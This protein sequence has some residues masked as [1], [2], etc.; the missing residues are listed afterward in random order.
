[1]GNRIQNNTRGDS[2]VGSLLWRFFERVGGQVI[3]FLVG[4]VLARLISP[5]EYASIAQ[6]TVF[7]TLA[8]TLVTNGFYAALVQ[9]R[10]AGE[11]DFS[12]VLWFAAL[13]SLLFYLAAFLAAPA[14]AA[15]YQMPVLCPV[16]RVLMLQVP[17]GVVYM[18]QTAYVARN[19][20]F[21][22][23]F[24]ST[25][26]GI[27]VSGLVGIA[28][29]RCGLG[30]WALVGVNLSGTLT[31]TLVLW[32]TVDWRPRLLFRW[33][34][35]KSLLGFGWKCL[36][37]SLAYNF[38]T[39]LPTLIV[40]KAF[41]E[42]S[43][44]Y[45]NKGTT[46]PYSLQSC[47]LGTLDSVLLSAAAREQE[48]REEVKRLTRRAIR[49][50]LYLLCPMMTGLALVARPLIELLL[51]EKWL[52]SVPYFRIACLAYGLNIVYA[53]F[54]HVIQAVGRSDVYLR[55][56]LSRLAEMALLCLGAVK[57][58]L[59]AV[60]LCVYPLFMIFNDLVAALLCRKYL[61]YRLGELWRDV[62][63]ALGLTAAMALPV[64]A[65]GRLS[66]GCWGLL[67]LQCAAGAGIYVLL[68]WLF[69]VES[70][71]YLLGELRRRLSLLT[72]GQ[73]EK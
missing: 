12:S 7:V 61:D 68:S 60:A 23:F 24:F 17:L 15:F 27:L 44:S 36:A 62:A 30:V 54:D 22:R 41:D 2:V 21:R 34:R 37:A 58:G 46:I 59:T 64:L 1:M 40:G 3:N 45:Y 72:G 14:V 31:N 43:L 42:T 69:R 10:E 73:R 47:V 35:V 32:F 70:F 39:Q 8:T 16:L 52:P 51:T 5:G 53:V 9:K 67:A 19:M 55:L 33:A 63:P 65:L 11:E 49:T 6:V 28:L 50:G 29:A 25:L 20:L 26:A 66:L 48:H 38:Y 57:A 71:R 13:L 4:V 18:V 56:H